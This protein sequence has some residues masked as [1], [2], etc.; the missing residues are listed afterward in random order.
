VQ[1][2]RRTGTVVVGIEQGKEGADGKDVV[3]LLKTR[4]GDCGST[5]GTQ[6][7]F[8]GIEREG[9]WLGQVGGSAIDYICMQCRLG[10]RV[11]WVAPWLATR[12]GCSPGR[13]LRPRG[14]H[15][16]SLLLATTQP[17]QCIDIDVSNVVWGC[18][19]IGRERL[20]SRPP[21]VDLLG[22][23]LASPPTALARRSPRVCQANWGG[24]C[25]SGE[26]GCSGFDV[27]PGATLLEPAWHLAMAFLEALSC[28][29]PLGPPSL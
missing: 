5:A 7:V 23:F 13:A 20:G 3:V 11:R 4:H 2:G 25:S 8:G 21:L 28:L 14:V 16:V 26:G 17:R 6:G 10:G 29:A 18:T 22:G 12:G 9:C 19:V 15:S 1:S 27:S 24:A